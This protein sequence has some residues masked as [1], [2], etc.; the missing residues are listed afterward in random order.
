MAWTRGG[1][2]IWTKQRRRRGHARPRGLQ[3]RCAAVNVPGCSRASR[4]AFA[5]TLAAAADSGGWG[6]LPGRAPPPTLQDGQQLT[7]ANHLQG[8]QGTCPLTRWSRVSKKAK[9]MT[10]ASSGTCRG[11][12]GAGGQDDDAGGSSRQLGAGWRGQPV[13]NA[14]HKNTK[15]TRRALSQAAG[16]RPASAATCTVALYQPMPPGTT[17][18]ICTGANFSAARVMPQ[19]GGKPRQDDVACMAGSRGKPR[20]EPVQQGPR[21]CTRP[22]QGPTTPCRQKAAPQ[23]PAL[24]RRP[25]VRKSGTVLLS[26][27]QQ[28]THTALALPLLTWV[29][30]AVE[31]SGDVHLWP[32]AQSR[33][34]CTAGG[35]AQRE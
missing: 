27:T 2:A 22:G 31:A 14:N 19:G 13:Q 3:V 25:A 6:A 5:K 15:F 35:A 17:L 32:A 12:R 21:R 7:K 10:C 20:A 23:R 11:Q 30:P 33:L 34:V 28:S 4:V 24:G 1:G 29:G 16:L 18:C 8:C 26:C 9:S